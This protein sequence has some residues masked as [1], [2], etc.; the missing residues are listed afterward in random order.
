MICDTRKL[1]T[2]INLRMNFLGKSRHRYLEFLNKIAG[3]IVVN[4]FEIEL[5]RY[6]RNPFIE[7]NTIL[8]FNRDKFKFN[9]YFE[10]I[11]PRPMLSIAIKT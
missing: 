11:S 3:K 10:R 8:S 1:G 4:T 7:P 9:D 5:I 2:Y 6:L